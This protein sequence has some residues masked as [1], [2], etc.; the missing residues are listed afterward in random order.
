M[1]RESTYSAGE[2][3]DNNFSSEKMGAHGR[4]VTHI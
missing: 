1:S 2:M 4:D 3:Q